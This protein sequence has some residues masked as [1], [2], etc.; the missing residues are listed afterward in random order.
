M[1]KQQIITVVFALAGVLAGV[2]ACG[3]PHTSPAVQPDHV[4]SPSTGSGRGVDGGGDPYAT[5]K[6]ADL[7][8]INSA[9]NELRYGCLAENGYP[10]F[11]KVLP[12]QK[13][14]AFRGMAETPDFASTFASYSELPWF[15]S[16]QDARTKGY[17]SPAQAL[18]PIVMTLDPAIGPVMNDCAQKALAAFEDREGTIQKYT[19]L[20]NT[21]A[22]SIDSIAGK[23][24][25]D[26]TNKVFACMNKGKYPVDPNGANK[27]NDWN[28][29][30]QVPMG[31][32]PPQPRRD[33]SGMSG[34]AVIIS[35]AVPAKPY[36]PTKEESESAA[37]MY[38]C[39]V[40]TGAHDEWLNDIHQAEATAVS[41]N[42][43]ALD[44][45]NPKITALAKSAS[46]ALQS[47]G[48]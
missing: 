30:F 15:D 2:G 27:A 35:P 33:G 43:A 24:K 47:H 28:V 7:L 21:L 40:E 23:A 39:S 26:L 22:E 3:S 29:D 9:Y 16:E 20:G 45:L 48:K 25:G 31:E 14:N 41:Q 11:L 46:A 42:E 8:A 4:N 10:Q 19:Q 5:Y 34:N 17:G 6:S 38:H 36:V 44:E 13:A 12:A 18:E 32:Q 37:A 1:K